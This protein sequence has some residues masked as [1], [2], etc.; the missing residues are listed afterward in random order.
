MQALICAKDRKSSTVLSTEGWMHKQTSIMQLLAH[1]S[2][3]RLA[4]Q[5]LSVQKLKCAISH[6][7][8]LAGLPAD[9]P[10]DQM[11][12]ML[13]TITKSQVP[14]H[15]QQLG[16]LSTLLPDICDCDLHNHIAQSLSVTDI[17]GITR[18]QRETNRQSLPL[19]LLLGCHI[20]RKKSNKRL[21]VRL[22]NDEMLQSGLPPWARALAV[23]ENRELLMSGCSNDD[24]AKFL[25]QWWES[26]QK[27][28]KDVAVAD[29]KL[30]SPQQKHS[31]RLGLI[32]LLYL[33]Q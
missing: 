17:I 32:L 8:S 15:V 2:S 3:K 16:I 20:A 29:G 4:T 21:A 18:I 7:E 26:V 13:E 25:V 24:T 31:E 28:I 30:L 5:L 33:V 10:L 12:T 27:E 22:L 11:S 19:F 6:S 14:Q 23:I 1:D 9:E